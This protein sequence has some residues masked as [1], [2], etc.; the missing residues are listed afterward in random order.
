[1]MPAQPVSAT[2]AMSTDPRSKLPDLYQELIAI[3]EVKIFVHDLKLGRSVLLLARGIAAES[4]ERS[5]DLQRIA[6][7]EGTRP[8]LE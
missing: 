2:I 6:R 8:D 1:M 7:P 4:P 5:E 3:H